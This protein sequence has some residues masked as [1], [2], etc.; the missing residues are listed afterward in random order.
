MAKPLQ[1]G[2]LSEGLSVESSAW[3]M[4]ELDTFE[5]L[6]LVALHYWKSEYESVKSRAEDWLER[7]VQL[8]RV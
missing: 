6:L 8:P 5:V 2:L 3:M 1:N 4:E 7:K